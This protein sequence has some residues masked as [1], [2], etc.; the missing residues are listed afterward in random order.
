MTP[1]A[2]SLLWWLGVPLVLGPVAAFL[3]GLWASRR[4]DP[5]PPLF[6]HD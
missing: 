4:P 6:S 2:L 5:V 3:Y 1:L